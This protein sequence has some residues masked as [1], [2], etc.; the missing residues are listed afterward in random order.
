MQG[1]LAVLVGFRSWQGIF[2]IQSVPCK[3]HTLH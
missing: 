1:A 2:K 3:H